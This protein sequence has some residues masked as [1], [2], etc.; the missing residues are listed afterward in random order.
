MSYRRNWTQRDRDIVIRMVTEGKTQ[1]EIAAALKCSI[2]TLRMRF[3]G[4]LRGGVKDV[5]ERVF[6]DP[7][8]NSAIALA[9][10]GVP[11]KHI[12]EM[13]DVSLTT[14]RKHLNVEMTKAPIQANAAVARA[15]WVKATRNGGE[16]N[17]QAFWLKARA[18]WTDRVAITGGL[19][20]N[21][22]VEHT[23]TLNLPELVKNLSPEGRA[24]LR[25]VAG[26]MRAFNE[27]NATRVDGDQIEEALEIAASE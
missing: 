2:S 27:A 9:S 19:D 20:V 18:G 21:G 22:T 3:K 15:L 6:T 12:A 26:E 17:A 8:R 5:R 4:P 10:Y 1:K 11:Q 23:H 7:E 14:L 13:L 25:V 16:F 24:A